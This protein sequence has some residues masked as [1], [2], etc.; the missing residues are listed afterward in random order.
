MVILRLMKRYK[1]NT[2]NK[3]PFQHLENKCI[4][5][6]AQWF[7]RPGI[8][9]ARP[10]FKLNDEGIARVIP[11]TNNGHIRVYSGTNHRALKTNTFILIHSFLNIYK[12]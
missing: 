9:R 4:V 11:R 2:R 5:F 10:L 3:S 6:K 8:T 7:A 12:I 1:H